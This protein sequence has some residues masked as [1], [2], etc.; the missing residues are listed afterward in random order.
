MEM[1]FDMEKRIE[2]AKKFHRLLYDEQP[3]TFLFTYKN[4]YFYRAELKNAKTSLV[5]P[6]F[7]PRP[8][9]LSA[10]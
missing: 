8:W 9:Y 6:Y 1:E 4:P 3:Y 10:P 5:R 2:L 7:N